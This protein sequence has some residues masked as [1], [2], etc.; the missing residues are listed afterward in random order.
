MEN[1]NAH[2]TIIP[3]ENAF[4][5][6]S[7]SPASTR[8]QSYDPRYDLSLQQ[9]GPE[10]RNTLASDCYRR[11]RQL[12]PCLPI[13]P[14]ENEDLSSSSMPPQIAGAPLTS[15]PDYDVFINH[16]GPDVKTSFATDLYHRL[17]H[18]GLRVFLDK[19]EMQGGLDIARQIKH[20]IET[21]SIG[22]AIFSPT[23]AESSYCLD[24]LH[25]MWKT[26]NSDRAIIIPVFYRVKP[27]EVRWPAK[28]PYGEA[29]LSH[30]M[31][32]RFNSQTIQDWKDALFHAAGISGFELEA[33]NGKDEKLLD[34]VVGR[35][36]EIGPKSP[37]K[38][39]TKPE[40]ERTVLLQQRSSKAMVVGIVGPGGVGKTKLAQ[41]F[42]N[43]KRSE[44]SG[45][46]F[47]SDV[48][49]SSGISLQRTL[50]KDL[51]GLEVHIDTIDKGKDELKMHIS[52]FYAYTCFHALIVLE[53]VD[54]A[55]QMDGVLAVRDILGSNSLI[56]VTSRD[57]QVLKRARISE[58]SIYNLT[59]LC[60]PRPKTNFILGSDLFEKLPSSL[61]QLRSLK[62]LWLHDSPNLKCLSG[63]YG[64]LNRLRELNIVD[65]GIQSLSEDLVKMNH[66]E[67]F[68]VYNCPLGELSFRK[69]GDKV[70]LLR[71]AKLLGV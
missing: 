65:C 41:D 29:L 42:F 64:L 35:I 38:Y 66:L 55:D 8:S 16:R 34:E 30:K 52:R 14:H 43:S 50:I 61:D 37:L 33:C 51:T 59:G 23:Y 4:A 63:P 60:T 26:C 5:S 27:S 6:S 68:R 32:G 45:S 19:P 2:R 46:C 36:L 67:V 53:D 1:T 15:Y 7:S 49:E 3:H 22:I 21:A 28:G 62:E 13:I 40:F 56:L 69:V 18:C 71:E 54:H 57:K 12:F 11:L 70:I 24:E 47:L 20:A 17:D 44:Y 39:V 9:R 25:R 58:T 10:V 31:K 48:K